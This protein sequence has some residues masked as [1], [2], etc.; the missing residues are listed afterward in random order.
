MSKTETG[1]YI[2]QSIVDRAD[3]I[4][5]ARSEPGDRV[6]RSQVLAEWV[7][8]GM[9]ADEELDDAPFGVAY[10]ERS[11]RFVRQAVRDLIAREADDV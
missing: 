9:A 3:E 7:R 8:L 11:Q 10:G 4:A 6:S 5:H 2:E 1:L